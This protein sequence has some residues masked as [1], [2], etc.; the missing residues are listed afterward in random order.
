MPA[1]T[2]DLSSCTAR[3][4]AE[5]W[6]KMRHT[7]LSAADHATEQLKA[8]VLQLIADEE[9]SESGAA[10]LVGVDRMTIRR[11]LGKR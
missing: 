4:A 7:F 10:R 1:A 8:L 11:W 6:A 9:I 2:P 5:E 3:E